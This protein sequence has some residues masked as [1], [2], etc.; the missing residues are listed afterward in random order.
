MPDQCMAF[1][2]KLVKTIATRCAIFCLK[3]NKN[4]LA[5][6]LCPD[7]LGELKCSPRPSSRNVG[8]TSKGRE[9]EG[10]AREKEKGKEETE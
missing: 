7:L 4:R 1:P 10:R 3:F 8:P 2:E 9:R 5:A 6:G